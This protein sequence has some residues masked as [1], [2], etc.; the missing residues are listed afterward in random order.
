MVKAKLR[1]LMAAQH[2]G[3]WDSE[4]EGLCSGT[5][6]GA[7][8]DGGVRNTLSTAAVGVV[9]C[10]FTENDG[11]IMDARGAPVVRC[12]GGCCRVGL[13]TNVSD[14]RANEDELGEFSAKDAKAS[15]G[16]NPL[17]IERGL[18]ELLIL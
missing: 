12:A 6:G 15:S 7:I 11:C 16:S 13:S 8:D 17:L 18:C 10:E 5:S 14:C 4:D 9:G 3:T 1:G 2:D